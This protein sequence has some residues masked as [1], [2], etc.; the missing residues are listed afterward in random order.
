MSLPGRRKQTEKA[1]SSVPFLPE[2]RGFRLLPE[3]GIKTA[4]KSD[5]S[6]PLCPLPPVPNCL[7]EEVNFFPP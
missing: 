1:V 3:E 7:P 4:A 5:F 2:K 6:G